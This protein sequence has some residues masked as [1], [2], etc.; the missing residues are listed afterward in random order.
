MESSWCSFIPHNLL[1]E[2]AN[3]DELDENIRKC[4]NETITIGSSLYDKEKKPAIVDQGDYKLDRAERSE[5]LDAVA[6]P[7]QF[8][9][10]D[11][12]LYDNRGGLKALIYTAGGQEVLPGHNALS[13]RGGQLDKTRGQNVQ[14]IVRDIF[15]FFEFEFGHRLF[16]KEGHTI[17][18]TINYGHNYTNAHWTGKRV[19]LGS[20]NPSLWDE[21]DMARDVIG[22]EVAHGVI[23]RTSGLNGSGEP[24]ALSE[25]LADVFG[26]LY[27]HNVESP[28]ADAKDCVWTIGESL[29]SPPGGFFG[30]SSIDPD[31]IKSLWTGS[32]G[33]VV[34]NHTRQDP[35]VARDVTSTKAM[36]FNKFP[37]Y[38]R[39]FKDPSSINPR[40]PMNYNDYKNLPYD[41]GGVHHNSG[42]GN[43]AFYVAADEAR[44][45]P[46]DGVGKVWFRAM[47]DTGLG[48]NCKYPRFAAFTIAYAKRDFPYLVKPIET[49]WEEVEVQP[50]DV[51]GLEGMLSNPPSNQ[52]EAREPVRVEESPDSFL[53]PIQFSP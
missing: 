50:D 25:H 36:H 32:G 30:F 35:T 9:L 31:I 1:S 6:L 34:D 22:H 15:S 14:S 17:A 46:L 39:S 2:L 23:L 33:K 24:G 40:Q 12:E 28:Y 52:H 13:G 21:F 18:I 16:E 26:L 38:L 27:K 53:V 10:I 37:H 29:W 20:G 42:I 51:P 48:A 11:G 19:I 3:D 4:M 43:Y 47:T 5:P 41:N 7:H 8:E 49:G 44:E 45:P